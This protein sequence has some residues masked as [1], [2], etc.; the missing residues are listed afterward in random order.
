MFGPIDPYE[1]SCNQPTIAK[2]LR[3][4]ATGGY[5]YLN[6]VEVF[7][8]PVDGENFLVHI[9]LLYFSFLV[10]HIVE[11]LQYKIQGISKLVWEPCVVLLFAIGIEVG[12]QFSVFSLDKHAKIRAIHAIMSLKV[13]PAS[14][15]WWAF[16]AK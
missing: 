15:I 14:L 4:A 6:E 13:L 5:L 8:I 3:L 10:F 11:N 1:T 7:G 9:I 16:V 2:F 12:A